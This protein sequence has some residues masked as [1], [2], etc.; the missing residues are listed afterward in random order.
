[1]ACNSISAERNLPCHGQRQLSVVNVIGQGNVD[2]SRAVTGELAK[3]VGWLKAKCNFV[4]RKYLQGDFFK[5]EVDAH[6]CRP[7][8][9]C[10]Y[11]P[12]DF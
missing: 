7:I 4:K 12:A 6:Q 8:M 9:R 11:C 10:S 5:M 1:M 2:K 3:R